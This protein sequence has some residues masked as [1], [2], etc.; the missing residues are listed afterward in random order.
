MR[1]SDRDD[2]TATPL[3]LA[4]KAAAL[5]MTLACCAASAESFSQR[6]AG[7]LLSVA[8]PLTTLG[9]EIVRGERA[10]AFQFTTSF[11]AAIGST[12]VLKRL[13]H[14][15]RP[16]GSDHLSFPSSH[17]TSAFSA[18]TYVHRRYGWESALPIYALGTYVGYTRV[19]TNDHRWGDIAGSAAV[20]AAMSWWLVTPKA[21]ASVALFPVMDRNFIGVGVAANW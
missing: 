9:T 8:I 16:D 2:L 6:R 20:S 18:A 7:D 4:G 19:R 15:E 12:L 11:A 3:V 5:V 14:E 21:N 1:F 17:A 10:G 13:T